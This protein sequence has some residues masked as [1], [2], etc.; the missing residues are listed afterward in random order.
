MSLPHIVSRGEW[1][2]QHDWEKP[3]GRADKP[4]RAQPGSTD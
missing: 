4:H 3:E 1:R 2:G